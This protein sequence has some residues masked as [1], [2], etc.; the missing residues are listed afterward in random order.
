[1]ISVQEALQLI[2]HNAIKGKIITLAVED[3]LGY[4]LAETALAKINMPPF[5]QS[6]MDGYAVHISN[7]SQK[8]NLIGEVKAGDAT[9]YILKEGEAIRIFTGAAVPDTANAVVMQEKVDRQDEVISVQDT[10]VVNLNIRPLAEQ[11][12]TGEKVVLQGTKLNPA[13]LSYLVSVG[14]ENLKVYRKPKVAILITG[15]E[16]IDIHSE[17][18]EGKIYESNSILLKSEL[19]QKGIEE[20]SVIK[21]VDDYEAT[22]HTLEMALD[23]H[24]IVLVSGGISVGDYDFVGEALRALGTEEIFYKIKQ[25]PG[26]PLFFGRRK[27]ALVFG[28]PGNPASALTCFYI[29]VQPV[30]KRFMGYKEIHLDRKKIAITHDYTVKGIRAQFLKASLKDNKVSI[31][32]QQSSAMIA[33]FIEANAYV[34]IPENSVQLKEGELVEVILL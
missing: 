11:C 18:K 12:A 26:K 13:A 33:A 14:V 20:I 23:T 15:S 29:Y 32:G 8:Y 25:K 22:K 16:L 10:P 31:T 6:A 19:H 3:C 30:L 7:A 1:M 4:V 34:F 24:D 17:Y 28:L 21:V 9:S 5:R 27:Q 2:E